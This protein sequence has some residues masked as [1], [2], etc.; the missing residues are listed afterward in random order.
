MDIST[1]GKD[2]EKELIQNLNDEIKVNDVKMDSEGI[3]VNITLRGK[4][5]NLVKENLLYFHTKLTKMMSCTTNTVEKIY[6]PV[7]IEKIEVKVDEPIVT[8]EPVASEEKL[9]TV[10][11]P[12]E[13]HLE[14]ETPV[15][16]ETPISVEE[17]N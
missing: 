9:E 5:Y 3:H 6:E 12:F 14:I 15:Q 7:A 16:I 10:K 2:L 4:L 8:K 11:E 1:H 13:E 17:R